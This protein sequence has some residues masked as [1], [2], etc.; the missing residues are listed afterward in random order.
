MYDVQVLM[1]TYNG[2]KYLKTQIDSILGQKGVR[3]HLLVRD[4]GSTDQTCK[5]LDEYSKA[6]C[7]IWYSG[8]NLQSAKSFMNLIN[9]SGNYEFFAFSDQDDYWKPE[10]LRVA[11]SEL[12][13][14]NK[15]IP[16]LYYGAATLVDADLKLIEQDNENRVF[17]SF[18]QAVISSSATGCTFC[19][20]KKLRD[21]INMYT[22][23]YQI[24]HDGWLHKV[25]LA[26]GGSVYYDRNSYILYRQHSNNVIGGTT[27]WGQKWKRR[28]E[29]IKNT[30][31]LRSKAITEL[32][33]GYRELLSPE[34]AQVC[35][36]VSN[37]KN[38]FKDK[39]ALLN[40]K[41]I[42]SP[43]KRIDSIYRL[44]VLLGVF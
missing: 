42:Y 13:K 44:S 27:T 34:N 9:N 32:Y 29:T 23:Q 22:P 30:P 28:I 39:I 11:I 43:N 17:T 18:N 26:V 2:E 20:N 35:L 37:Y 10:K 31:C 16:L 1:S 15:K 4:D 41:K 5:I 3:V 36:L 21:V 7:L 14:K 8:E 38:S 24:M 19:F 40:N 25:C 6:G 33:K 12:N